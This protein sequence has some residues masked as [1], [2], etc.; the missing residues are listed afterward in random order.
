MRQVTITKTYLKFNELNE[1]QQ[2]KV[3]NHLRDINLGHEWYEFTQEAF[4]TALETLGF[5]NIKSQFSG[6][7]S[8]GDGASF[9]ANFEL[10]KNDTDLKE[11]VEKLLKDAPYF[12]HTYAD[13]VE[14]MKETGLKES[15][16][17]LDFTNEIEEGEGQITVE[18][19]GHYSHEYTMQC[20]NKGLQEFSRAMA[21]KY[22]MELEKEYEYQ[23]S[24]E[25]IKETIESN[26]YEFDS[27]TLEIV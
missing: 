11:R 15:F 25:A 16:L 19:R 12:F 26:D 2:R 23:T 21:A 22:Y 14:D 17:N 18:Q 10:P 27:E 5:S 4:H 24:D 8:Q 7:W 1:E 13:K 3:L 6:F 20:W 9:N